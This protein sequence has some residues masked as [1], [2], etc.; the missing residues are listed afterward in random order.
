[1][2]AVLEAFV[3]VAMH[4]IA[5]RGWSAGRGENSLAAF[6]RAARDDA[7]SGVEFDVCRAAGSGTM[8]VSHDP[9]LHTEDLLTLD[10]ALSSLS[11]TDLELFVEIK[12]EGLA[13]EVIE[14]LVSKYASA[15]DYIA[16]RARIVMCIPS[17]LSNGGSSQS[18]G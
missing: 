14:K 3:V 6:A 15:L 9:P 11:R 12:E 4:L 8:V 5:H 2:A 13:L 18:I 17:S 1:M 16:L 7:V 10:T